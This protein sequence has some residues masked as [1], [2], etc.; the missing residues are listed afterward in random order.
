M[1]IANSYCE[2]VYCD[3]GMNGRISNGGVVNNTIY[4]EQFA[5]D[6]LDPAPESVIFDLDLENVFVGED[7]FAMQPDLIKPTVG[8]RLITREEY[9]TIAYPEHG[10]WLRTDLEF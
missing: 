9:A 10:E 4:Y 5:N 2:F 7:A 3:V 6:Q 1:A 8:I